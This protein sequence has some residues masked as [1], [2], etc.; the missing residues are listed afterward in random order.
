MQFVVAVFSTILWYAALA[1]TLAVVILALTRN[2][3][4]SNLGEFNLVWLPWLVW[5]L[6]FIFGGR[7]NS[8]SSA[9]VESIL[10]A[11]AAGIG[12]GLIPTLRKRIKERESRIAYTIILVLMSIAL[13]YTFPVLG[14]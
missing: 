3:V 5:F 11:A 1:G 4:W 9:L 8:L 10:L 2:G 13:V 14:E 6:L 12:I 7:Y